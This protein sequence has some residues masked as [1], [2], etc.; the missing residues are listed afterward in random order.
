MM[1]CH[2]EAGDS[3]CKVGRPVCYDHKTQASDKDEDTEVP[4]PPAQSASPNKD[5]SEQPPRLPSITE[6]DE[7]PSP[8]E[9]PSLSREWSRGRS[10]PPTPVIL[11]IC[12]REEAL[13]IAR[14]ISPLYDTS[15][16]EAGRYLPPPMLPY[17]GNEVAGYLPPE[18]F[19]SPAC[20][21][22]GN[23]RQG[24]RR[25][26]GFGIFCYS[27]REDAGKDR[28]IKGGQL[29]KLGVGVVVFAVVSFVV[30]IVVW[31]KTR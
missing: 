15:D 24:R 4:P 17:T 7:P 23:E 31:H 1:I 20:L 14:S 8:T 25:F 10:P 11:P 29:W 12:D 30:A 18:A 21:A 27:Q 13:A 6:D 22:E 5:K 19:P 3:H 28:W 26:T 9:G 16:E 2:R